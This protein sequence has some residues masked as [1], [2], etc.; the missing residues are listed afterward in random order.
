MKKVT[1][2]GGA[3]GR[4]HGIVKQFVSS[5]E[6]QTSAVLWAD[7][8]F[9]KN[10]CSDYKVVNL[11]N[12][13]EVRKTIQIMKPDYVVVGQGEVTQKG[14]RDLLDEDK[15]PCI[16]PTQSM[17]Q[18]EGSKS[19]FRELLEGLDNNLIPEYRAFTKFDRRV[20]DF[21]E[22]LGGKVVVK[23]DKTIS[24]PRVRIYNSS[25]Q[26]AEAVDNSREWVEKHGKIVL[27]ELISGKEVAVMSFTDGENLVHTP[28]FRNYK[29]IYDN[30]EGENTSGMGSITTGE[31]LP[32]MNPKMIRGIH[33]ITERLLRWIQENHEKR[34]L[35]SLYGEF[36]VSD[37]GIKVIEYNCRFGNPSTMNMLTLIKPNFSKVCEAILEKRVGELRD[38]WKDECSLSAYVV[39]NRYPYSE[40][41]VGKKVDFSAVNPKMFLCGNMNYKD[42]IWFLKK[43]RGF[44]VCSTG[45][46]IKDVREK[47]YGELQKIRGPIHYRKDI[48]VKL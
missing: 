23:C 38:I 21:I 18:I 48:G 10:L 40:V 5:G 47:V 12:V 34:F 31:R 1:I 41:N 13:A 28:P 14:L 11:D 26:I 15:I 32:F 22:K 45:K 46:D 36:F 42:D 4:D 8:P 20:E 7:N 17:A 2:V 27:E 43:S 3:T 24:G 25:L 6:Y 9:I 44:A 29:R 33:S 39:P 35:G 19:F 16:A 37:S 30:D